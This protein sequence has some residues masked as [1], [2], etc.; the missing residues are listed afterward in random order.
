MNRTVALL[1]LLPMAGTPDGN[2]L[3]IAAQIRNDEQP[4]LQLEYVQTGALP[5]AWWLASLG[6]YTLLLLARMSV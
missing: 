4:A 3:R 2:E 1:C 5:K 6:F